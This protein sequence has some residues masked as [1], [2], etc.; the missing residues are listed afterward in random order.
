MKR[1]NIKKLCEAFA[2]LNIEMTDV[3]LQQL[4]L[5][6]EGVLAWN[7]HVNL[8]AITEEDDFVQKHFIDSLLCA[9]A[10][11]FTQ[12]RTVL[13][14]GTGGGFPGI[15]LAIA[16][17]DKQFVLA[18][19]LNKRIR[20]IDELSAKAGILN[21]TPVHG[22]AEELARKAEYREQFDLCVSRA[23]ANMSTLSEYCLPYVKVGGWCIAYKGPDCE[24]EV[25]QAAKAIQ[26]LG[27]GKAEIRNAD[28]GSV[29]TAS[30][31]EGTPLP[32]QHKLVYIKKI[33]ST[34]KTYPRK[35]G[36]PGKDPIK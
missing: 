19:S 31:T 26:R 34:P 4:Q 32:F 27:G 25:A 14:M 11:E 12:A 18:D 29:I 1:E 28:F 3:K 22:R 33:S 8:T 15:P 2:N 36:T 10:P 20:I 35:A 23:V 24:A 13:D 6:M 21:V 9:N 7:E 30:G 16:F 5:Y 17:P